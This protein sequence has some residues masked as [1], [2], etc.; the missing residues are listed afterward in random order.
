MPPRCSLLRILREMSSEPQPSLR[1]KG[2]RLKVGGTV[3]NDSSQHAASPDILL[4]PD[5]CVVGSHGCPTNPRSAVI[6][7][8]SHHS[9]IDQSFAIRAPRVVLRI[10]RLS[11]SDR[12]LVRPDQPLDIYR[13]RETRSPPRCNPLLLFRASSYVNC[14]SHVILIIAQWFKPTLSLQLSHQSCPVLEVLV[15]SNTR[16]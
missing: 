13:E 12:G 15:P 14:Y 9:S 4:S 6:K 11:R 3:M 16:P 10:V 2:L 7:C 1:L 8:V 5:P